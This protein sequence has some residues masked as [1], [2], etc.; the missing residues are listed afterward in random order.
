MAYQYDAI[1]FDLGDVLFDWSSSAITVLA[2]KLVHLMMLT[3]AWH[4]LERKLLS[5]D[6][7]YTIFG[8]EHNVDPRLIRQA[9]DQA[10]STF[11]VCDEATVLLQE[12]KQRDPRIKLYIMSNIAQEHMDNLYNLAFPWHIFDRVFTSCGVGMRKP[13]LA[14]YRHVIDETGCDPVRTLYLDDKSEN[15]CAGR[16]LGLRGEI[17]KRGDRTRVFNLAR[18]LLLNDAPQRAEGF[19][20]PNAKRLHSVVIMGQGEDDVLFQDNFS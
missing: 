2:K 6:E 17:V 12:L 14:F 7:A 15:I 11:H 1:I 9:L 5:A 8:A 13:E 4:N 20:R 3:T 10:Q 19:L 16:I 18:N